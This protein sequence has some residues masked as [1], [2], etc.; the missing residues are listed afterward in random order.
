MEIVYLY[1]HDYRR[2]KKQNINFGSEYIFH[3]DEKLKIFSIENNNLYI[4]NFYNQNENN[5]ISNVSAIIGEN[6]TGKTGLIDYII[7]I[8]SDGALFGNDEPFMFIMKK[9]NSFIL[10]YSS[11]FFEI[12][13][14][15]KLPKNIQLKASKSRIENNEDIGISVNHGYSHLNLSNNK[16]RTTIL[17]I[18]NILFGRSLN[19][20][21]NIFDFTNDGMIAKYQDGDYFKE[22]GITNF[23]NS[24][25]TENNENYIQLFKYLNATKNESLIPFKIPHLV[26]IKS[27][28][29]YL[30]INKTIVSDKYKNCRSLSEK[31]QKSIELNK[32]IITDSTIKFN[33][34][35]NIIL[36]VPIDLFNGIIDNL[37]SVDINKYYKLIEII[38]EYLKSIESFLT[39]I[40]NVN[41]LQESQDLEVILN[42]WIQS[43]LE[44]YD[45]FVNN[46]KAI[47]GEKQT[48]LGYTQINTLKFINKILETKNIHPL[49]I[50]E[51]RGNSSELYFAFEEFI[52]SD[53]LSLYNLSSNFRPFVIFEFDVP[54]S[55][56]QY[57]FLNIFSRINNL[58]KVYGIGSNS[59]R[60]VENHI[61]LVIDEIDLYLHPNWQKNIVN[62]LSAFLNKIHHQYNFQIIFTANNP[63]PISDL[64]SYNTIFLSNNESSNETIVKD[65]LEDQKQTFAANIHTLLADSFFVKGGLIGDFSKDKIN[66]VIQLIS[67]GK[68]LSH[69]E[70]AY[71]K[72]L[73]K[74]IGEPLIKNKLLQ[75]Y[76]QN[77]GLDYL[78]RLERVEKKLGLND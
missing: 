76:T 34:V 39:S 13:N 30:Y 43:L 49:H 11:D 21:S 17:K 59:N 14:Y 47:F 46:F 69:D 54:L 48:Q 62:T 52:G 41:L 50:L 65:S 3:Y 68:E 55:S 73:I 75:M 33:F 60:N 20:F 44:H 72:K 36:N 15:E 25:K 74:Q 23:Y 6:G 56:G 31:L 42:G 27:I 9:D 63:L 53:I 45:T 64:L 22:K 37:E 29:D 24:L 38:E 35:F 40:V 70:H 61:L 32:V 67:K 51:N 26:K 8:Y 10:H 5:N 18:S 66:E 7:K 58:F 4:D 2:F 16:F 28:D 19:G 71:I 57:A 12:N 78:E 77:N 1:I